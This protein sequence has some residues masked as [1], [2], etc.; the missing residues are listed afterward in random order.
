MGVGQTA[1]VE[2][3]K[4]YVQHV[5]VRLLDLVEEDYRVRLAADALGKLPLLVVADVAGRRADELG[6]GMLLHILRH[7]EAD[8]VLFGIEQL[9][10]HNAHELG[11]AD[12]GRTHEDEGRGPAP[13]RKSRAGALDRADDGLDRLVLPD[14]ALLYA[15]LEERE[16]IELLLLDAVGGDTCPHLN[17]GGELRYRD[18]HYQVLF[19]ELLGVLF[20]TAALDAQVGDLLEDL[21]LVVLNALG[22]LVICQLL[23]ARREVGDLLLKLR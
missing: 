10:R 7:I 8:E 11:L 15:L 3:L 13:R 17:D 9:L 2:Y 5:G 20:E 22:G 19:A 12:A 21:V 16:L 6:D 14:D 1:L 18:G 4:Q 23:L